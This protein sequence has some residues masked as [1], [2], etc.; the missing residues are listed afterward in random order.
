[1]SHAP[2]ALIPDVAIEHLRSGFASADDPVRW[3][4]RQVNTNMEA[5]KQKEKDAPCSAAVH[6]ATAQFVS[7]LLLEYS[8]EQMIS[9]EDITTIEVDDPAFHTHRT[10]YE[11]HV[12][13]MW[14]QDR[15][16]CMSWWDWENHPTPSV[17]HPEALLEGR[18]RYERL[19]RMC[20][21]RMQN[22]RHQRQPEAVRNAGIEL[23]RLAYYL[24]EHGDEQAPE[25]Y[26]VFR[27]MSDLQNA[28][29][30][31]VC[32]PIEPINN[33]PINNE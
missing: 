24:D 10:P 26:S 21:D 18:E 1:M 4:R 7:Q 11:W 8:R 9:K 22:F 25:P 29:A 3:A 33:E 17:T 15:A 16:D 14:L 23:M 5:A 19:I 31:V 32:V 27:A 20:E 30:F 13:Y 12:L 2:E 28:F 6:R